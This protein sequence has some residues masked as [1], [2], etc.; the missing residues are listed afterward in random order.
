MKEPKITALALTDQ[1][2]VIDGLAAVKNEMESLVKIMNSVYIV[3]NGKGKPDGFL[4]SVEEET[5]T[6]QLIKMLGSIQAQEAAY[7]NAAQSAGLTTFKPITFEG[8]TVEDWK[9][10]I[11]LRIKQLQYKERF[12]QLQE[13]EKEGRE[14]M[15]KEERKQ[16]WMQKMKDFSTE[17]QEKK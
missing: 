2:S 16:I 7:N 1:S 6:Q 10:D 12:E 15:G 13:M 11:T 5:D 17:T 4:K 9:K 8:G 3:K 14:L